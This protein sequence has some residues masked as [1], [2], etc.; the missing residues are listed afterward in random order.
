MRSLV[1]K[2]STA[3]F[4]ASTPQL[5][6]S[7]ALHGYILSLLLEFLLR[8]VSGYE[9]S[10][11][12]YCWAVALPAELWRTL[13]HGSAIRSSFLSCKNMYI[14]PALTMHHYSPHHKSN[15]EMKKKL[16]FE[17]FFPSS[18]ERRR[19]KLIKHWYGSGFPNWCS[20]MRIR[21]RNIAMYV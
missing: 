14:W 2:P 20:L 8:C 5:W 9:S 1:L 6:A 12:L 21:I 10:C 7:T 18:W 19:R 17:T 4:W 3:P 16:G 13:F 15:I 11:L